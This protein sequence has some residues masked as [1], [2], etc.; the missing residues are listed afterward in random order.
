MLVSPRLVSQAPARSRSL[1]RPRC[2]PHVSA[3]L[4]LF[5]SFPGSEQGGAL[6]ITGHGH[7]LMGFW[8]PRPHTGIVFRQGR[9]GTVCRGAVDSCM[10]PVRVLPFFLLR[11][12]Y[13]L[14]FVCVHLA[15][16]AV[17]L[18][19]A[20]LSANFR[21]AAKRSI[22]RPRVTH[23][24]AIH[25]IHGQPTTA[26]PIAQLR[27][28][29]QIFRTHRR[30]GKLGQRAFGGPDQVL[31][32]LCHGQRLQGQ[33]HL[34]GQHQLHRQPPGIVLHRHRR[35][36]HGQRL[37]RPGQRTHVLHRHRRGAHG[38]RLQL[39]LRPLNR[40]RSPAWRP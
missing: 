35:G 15:S 12:Y 11:D 40:P 7:T 13:V 31:L 10:S 4:L 39:S 16:L 27:T 37:R 26:G 25:C 29:R 1:R 33:H 5:S 20:Y 28:F 24:T 23:N 14:H 18:G 3:L 21:V 6:R 8:L 32:H 9:G 34:A 22:R 2:M 36:A 38:Q 17:P 19:A 30:G